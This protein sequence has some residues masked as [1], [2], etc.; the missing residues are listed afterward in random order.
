MNCKN[1]NKAL[2]KQNLIKDKIKNIE[3]WIMAF[4]ISQPI[5]D[6]YRCNWGDTISIAG[7]AIE[8]IYNIVFIGGMGIYLLYTWYQKN[9]WKKSKKYIVYFVLVILYMM[10]HYWNITQFNADILSDEEFNFV[11]ECYYMIRT[12]LLP[13]LLMFIFYEIGISTVKFNQIIKW[14]V[15]VFASCIV[16]TNLLEI[17]YVTYSLDNKFI[18]GSILD[19][20]NLTTQSDLDAYT[21]KGWF[22]SGNQISALLFAATPIVVKE[23]L[24]KANWKNY[25]LLILDIIAMIMIGTRTSALG[26]IMVMA[27]VILCTLILVL[28]KLEKKCKWSSIF[29]MIGI[30]ILGIVVLSKSPIQYKYA[31][32]QRQQVGEDETRNIDNVLNEEEQN[33][34]LKSL[35]E[36]LDKYGYY[37]YIN[38][39]FLEVYPPEKDPEFWLNVMQR[40]VAR[41][42][43]NRTFKIEIAERVVELNNRNMDKWLGIGYTANLAYTERDYVFQYYIFGVLGCILFI[44]PVFYFLL[45]SGFRILKRYKTSLNIENVSIGMSLCCLLTIAYLSGH[46]FGMQLNMFFMSLY[47]AKL[48]LNTKK[49][50]ELIQ[51]I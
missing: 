20:R 33:E 22:Y 42:I 51:E 45:A 49:S 17:S 29:V 7:I 14:T 1:E 46:V 27:V 48:L 30:M 28:M 35:A 4:F 25:A 38:S 10:A 3:Y 11:I 8:E 37:Y 9:T 18:E 34:S 39:Y 31:E 6:I 26:G 41:N 47:G 13:I 21:S 16:I 40:D 2:Q 43:N 32:E 23:T 36:Y 24:L 44:G 5:L 19:W 15:F 50:T 12:Y